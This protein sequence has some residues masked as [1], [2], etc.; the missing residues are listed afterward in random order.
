MDM[1]NFTPLSKSFFT[2]SASLVAARLL[3]HWLI[4]RT[5]TGYCGG[6]IVETEA[7]LHGDPAS[8]GF[9]GET[10]RTRVMFGPPGYTY[11]YFI[12]G[13]HY[14]VNAVCRRPGIAEAVLIRA[15]EPKFGLDFLRLNRPARPDHQLTNGPGKLCA[16]M[17]IDLTQNGAD[18]CD[19]NSPLFIARNTALG[20]FRRLHQPLLVTKRIG[21]TKGADSPLRF[22]LAGSRY[23]SSSVSEQ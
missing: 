14:C 3:G 16:A 2:P 15:I 5:E 9:I 7:Y 19:P 12:Y 11:V 13:N 4:R 17:K 18:L 8:H 20:K 22:C 1:T 6:P 23:V 10:A 21:I